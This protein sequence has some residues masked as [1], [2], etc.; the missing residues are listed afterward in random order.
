MLKD[1]LERIFEDEE[2]FFYNV[3]INQ[4]FNIPSPFEVAKDVDFPQKG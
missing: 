4:G 2:E 3:M 1:N